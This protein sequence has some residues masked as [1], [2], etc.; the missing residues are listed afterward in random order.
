MRTGAHKCAHTLFR[1]EFNWETT[2]K[3]V[4]HHFATCVQVFDNFHNFWILWAQVRTSAHTVGRFSWSYVHLFARCMLRVC[5]EISIGINGNLHAICN[6]HNCTYL[7]LNLP[8][9]QT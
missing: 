6:T 3:H 8:T 7:Q 2:W 5:V 4:F 9:I 1:H